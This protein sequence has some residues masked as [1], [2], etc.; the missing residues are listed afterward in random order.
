MSFSTFHG[1]A[2]DRIRSAQVVQLPKS[3]TR[4]FRRDEDGTRGQILLFTGVRY[5]RIVDA[6]DAQASPQRKL[7]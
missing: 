5:E 1:T 4:R 6:D 7:S 3:G 2:G